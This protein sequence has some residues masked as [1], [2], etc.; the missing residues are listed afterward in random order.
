MLM[1]VG[2][3]SSESCPTPAMLLGQSEASKLIDVSIHMQCGAS[4]GVGATVATTQ[5]RFLT[6]RWE[7]MS[8]EPLNMTYS[9]LR[10]SLSLDSESEWP[11]MTFR[12]LLAF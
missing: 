10:C 2:E 9:I 4:F 3:T 5:H 7:V 1:M 11:Y 6:M 8:Q 12:S